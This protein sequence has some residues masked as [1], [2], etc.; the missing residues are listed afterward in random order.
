MTK[1]VTPD[2]KA[3]TKNGRIVWIGYHAFQI[4]PENVLHEDGNP[5]WYFDEAQEISKNAEHDWRLPTPVEALLI[6]AQICYDKALKLPVGRAIADAIQ[7]DFCGTGISLGNGSEFF[8]QEKGERVA[9]WTNTYRTCD[10]GVG[11]SM[12]SGY[13]F[14]LRPE[15]A[16]L[17]T[18]PL[19]DRG[20]CV[21]LVR[22]VRSK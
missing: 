6:S 21:R 22:L 1:I 7:A 4:A 14:M 18:L 16:D 3:W 9:F 20:A 17:Y 11:S 19:D 12:K 13:T 5:W 2:Y 15:Y 10:V 8:A